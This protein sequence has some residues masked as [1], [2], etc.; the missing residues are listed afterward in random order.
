[1]TMRT[2][3]RV[4]RIRFIVLAF[5]L[6]VLACMDA[7]AA[8]VGRQIPV[9]RDSAGSGVTVEISREGSRQTATPF[10]TVK[11]L[12]VRRIEE[13]IGKLIDRLAAKGISPETVTPDA[14][15]RIGRTGTPREDSTG[16]DT[17]LSSRPPVPKEVTVRGVKNYLGGLRAS[18]KEK[19]AP[20]V[21]VA[22]R[23]QRIG[24]TDTS[25]H[26]AN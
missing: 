19:P 18:R 4:Q 2:A 3:E 15:S 10:L 1:M 22:P 21:V 24:R 9:V 12:T 11:K 23:E 26:A 5:A 8:D 13:R 25:P 17:A 7:M 16:S 6:V 20:A 14:L